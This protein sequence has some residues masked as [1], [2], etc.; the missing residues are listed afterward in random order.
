[1]NNE[2]KKLKEFRIHGMMKGIYCH[3]LNYIKYPSQLA[4]IYNPDDI[5]YEIKNVQ[6]NIDALIAYKEVLSILVPELK[7][8][9]WIYIISI[10]SK[11]ER[12]KEYM[13]G[14]GSFFFNGKE[15]K[16]NFI[17]RKT[18]VKVYCIEVYRSNAE[19]FNPNY[20]YSGAEYVNSIQVYG[21]ENKKLANEVLKEVY[22]VYPIHPDYQNKTF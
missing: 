14:E 12:H 1:M 16:Y 22:S 21:S 9:N 13:K 19:T 5:N 2:E 15:T 6:E 8:V 17:Q 10:F 7:P 20:P 11:S 4:S 18:S 3:S